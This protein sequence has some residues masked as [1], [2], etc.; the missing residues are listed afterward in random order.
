MASTFSSLFYH[1]VFSTKDRQ[2]SMARS[3]RA[4]LYAYIGGIVRDE[5]GTLLAAGGTADH[6]HLLILSPPNITVS[7]MV[8]TLKAGSS[9]WVNAEG[10]SQGRFEWQRGYGAFS[11]SMS[12]IPAV[13]QYIANQEEHHRKTTFREEIVAL[14]SKHGIEYDERYLLG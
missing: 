12:Q 3:W 4:D 8:G 11:V 14:L 1:V 13:K 7:K 9:R 5:R 10:K 2:R 6:V